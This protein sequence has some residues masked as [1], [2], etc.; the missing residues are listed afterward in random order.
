MN[1][2]WKLIIRLSAFG[3]AM[4]IGTVWWIPGNIELVIWLGIFVYCAYM[5]A[6]QASG[7]HFLHGFLISMVNCIWVTSAHIVFFADYAASH[8]EE[9]EWSAKMTTHPRIMMAVMGPIFG[10]VMGLVLG[11]FCYIAAKIAR[12]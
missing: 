2:N 12:K 9:M 1:L 10:A 8:P 3:L 4:A 7:L 11:L 5:V 6:Q